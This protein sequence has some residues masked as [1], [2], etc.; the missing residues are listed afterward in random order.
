M[1]LGGTPSPFSPIQLS[2]PYVCAKD[3]NLS[4]TSVCVK[5]MH[6][7]LLTESQLL[8]LTVIRAEQTLNAKEA[9]PGDRPPSSA[10]WEARRSRT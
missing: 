9:D 4:F 3:I 7:L 10:G 6:L 8:L 2:C 5:E 1:G